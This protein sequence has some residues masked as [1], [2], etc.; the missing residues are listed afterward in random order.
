[1]SC[2]LGIIAFHQ[3]TNSALANN[4][5][6]CDSTGDLRPRSLSSSKRSDG[7]NVTVFLKY[8]LGGGGSSFSLVF[9]NDVWS[10]SG[11]RSQDARPH[12]HRRHSKF[13]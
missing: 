11:R 12:T 6:G 3:L 5:P 4:M 9:R 10:T 1:M 13:T 2:G 8:Y 7:E